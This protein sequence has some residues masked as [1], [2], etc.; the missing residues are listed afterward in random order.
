MTFQTISGKPVTRIGLGTWMLGDDDNRR[1]QEL[2]A[3]RA[4]IEAGANLLDTAEM[5]G[6]GRAENLLGEAM[7]PYAREDLF[8]VSK[9]YPW[10][11]DK[12]HMEDSLTY[13]L[14]RL[15]TNYLDL[16]LLH[17]P[18]QVPLEETVALFEAF[19]HQGLI[20]AWGVSNFDT[21]DMQE[22][23]DLP[24]GNHCRTNQVLYNIA[25]RGVEFD[26]LPWMKAHDLPLMAYC[27]LAQ[28]GELE[29]AMYQSEAVQELCED[30]AISTEQLM[31]AFLLTHEGV[32][33]IPRSSS[34]AHTL[35]NLQAL[36][37]HLRP[38]ELAVIEAAFPKPLTKQPL[39]VV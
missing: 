12:G 2:D 15:G 6:E 25:D 34:R 7:A 16:Y 26:L 27:P 9:V 4:G 22:L 5:Y 28:G 13:T 18:G 29:D 11:A 10:N 8:V 17:W 21:P 14:K 33:P 36:D 39:T 23:W 30:R 20:R 3:L 38:E 24:D 19:K 31:L 1:P 35:A 37:I 32:Y